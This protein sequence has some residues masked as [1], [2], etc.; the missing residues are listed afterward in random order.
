MGADA[1][2]HHRRSQGLAA[3]AQREMFGHGR[4]VAGARWV[5][6]LCCKVNTCKRCRRLDAAGQHRPQM[7]RQ[8]KKPAVQFEET[9]EVVRPDEDCM[10][11]VDSEADSREKLDQRK[12]EIEK[13]LRKIEE[14]TDL[15]E[16]FVES[17]KK[18]WQQELLQIEQRRNDLLSEHEK[19]QKKSQK[20]QSL[21]DKL[22]QCRKIRRNLV[23]TTVQVRMEIEENCKKNWRTFGK[24]ST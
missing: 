14:F 5:F 1:G 11:E 23:R 19:I 4:G 13:Q 22:L 12:S 16:G 10:M 9:S 7:I 21:Q 3:S 15:D 20:L 2:D 18:Q 24:R 6:R 8:G 17:W